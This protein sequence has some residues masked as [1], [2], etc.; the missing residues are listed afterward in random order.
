MKIY[1]SKIIYNEI[2]AG[3]VAGLDSPEKVM[4]YMQGAFDEYPQQEAM[5]IIM[6]NRKNKPL[7]RHL[8]SLGTANNSLCHPREVYRPAVIASASAIIVVHNH[9]SGDPAPSTS[10]IK[11]TRQLKE[12]SKIMGIDLLDHVI[13]GDKTESLTGY[14]SFSE[15]GLI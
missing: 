2:S 5:Y 15:A 3:K 8:I 12:A 4:Q 7:G 9:P 1:E 11:V 13:A 14:Y 10:D 6:L